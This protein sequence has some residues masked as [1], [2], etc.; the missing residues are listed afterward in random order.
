MPSLDVPMA[1]LR[2][3]FA[4][5]LIALVS[6]TASGAIS[7]STILAPGGF[8]QAGAYSSTN[9]GGMT[10]GEDMAGNYG[11]PE[12]FSE[13]E[14][15]GASFAQV[16]A[17]YSGGFISNTAD[18]TANLGA[19]RAFAQNSSPHDALFALGSA[20]GG[21]KES[22][23]VGNPA[24]TG[25]AGY[26]VF[27]VR[28]RGSL[29]TT[30]YPGSASLTFSPYLNQQLMVANPFYTNAR[31]YWAIATDGFNAVADSAVDA[32]VTFGAPIT[33]GQPF[34]LGIYAI[35]NAGMRSV[36]GTGLFGTGLSDFSSDGVT[37]NGIVNV[38]DAGGQSVAGSTITS[39]SGFDWTGPFTPYV[40]VEHPGAPMDM[41]IRLVSASPSAGEVRLSLLL[42]RAASARVGVYDILGRQIRALADGW[43]PAGRNE[44]VWDGRTKQGHVAGVGIYFVRAESEG[45]VAAQRLVRVR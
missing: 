19:F 22:L 30:G 44:L 29:H 35:A 4:A 17:A 43:H 23:T 3:V 42:P 31:G 13:Q 32:V 33:F 26:L 21:W 8:A 39:G 16:A 18:A 41:S 36:S 27:Q 14:F 5:A 9:G 1:A 37:W 7:Q 25:Q 2:C 11:T 28:A 34:T 12:N 20:T 15:T 40:G 38:L 6:A 24:L 10:P 45:K